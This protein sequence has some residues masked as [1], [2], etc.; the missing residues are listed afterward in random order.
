M[1]CVTHSV[2]FPVQSVSAKKEPKKIEKS[3]PA[4]TKT[5]PVKKKDKPATPL[6]KEVCVPTYIR[7][8]SGTS[9]WRKPL[10]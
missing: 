3:S 8:Y 5:T 1:Q 2:L 4:V 9:K 7:T 6:K 10:Y